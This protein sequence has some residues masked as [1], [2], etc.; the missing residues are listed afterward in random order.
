M[1]TQ[2]YTLH[3]RG[4]PNDIEAV[5]EASWLAGVPP[6]WALANGLWVSLVVMT[7]VLVFVAANKPFGFGL[8]Y[9]GLAAICLMEGGALT[10]AEMRLRGWRQVG[11][12][13][14]RTPEGAIELYLKGEA[15]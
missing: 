14:A 6:L 3:S 8:T 10:R 11:V 2:I 4:D 13:E 5:G 7:A 9:L 1:E 15:A 12:V